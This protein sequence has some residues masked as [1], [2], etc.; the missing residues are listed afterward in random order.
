VPRHRR[1]DHRCVRGGNRAGRRPVRVD[2]E[3]RPRGEGQRPL[4]RRPL[5]RDRPPRR[6][7]LHDRG[8][9]LREQS[10]AVLAG[11]AVYASRSSRPPFSPFATATRYTSRRGRSTIL[12]A[13]FF[14]CVWYTP[15]ASFARTC[16][17]E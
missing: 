9:V 15:L 17:I 13:N 1:T 14:T 5:R 2:G 16:S 12:S 3:A 10:G 11:H 6:G 7:L 4:L 8:G